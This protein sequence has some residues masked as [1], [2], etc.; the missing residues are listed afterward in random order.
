M[1]NASLELLGRRCLVDMTI[2]GV[3]D[4]ASLFYL[5][6]I[7]DSIKETA[8]EVPNYE[9]LLFPAISAL[10]L[11]EQLIRLV[12]RKELTRFEDGVIN[13][14]SSL[15]FS[16]CRIFLYVAVVKAFDFLY[17]NYRIVDLPLHSV[18]T[19][20]I[21]L[22]LVEFVY[23]WTHRALHEFNIL[24]AAHQFHHMA[25]DVNITTTVRDSVVDLIIYDVSWF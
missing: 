19:W 1:Q 8:E 20:V 13:V 23:Y 3:K 5:F 24:W 25:E 9:I 15:L 16:L 2:S 21:S 10:I 17:S 14:G 18:A 7:H 11:I 22:L 12:Q 4:F 6:D